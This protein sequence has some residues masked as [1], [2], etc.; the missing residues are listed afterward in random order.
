MLL[1]VATSTFLATFLPLKV[2][3]YISRP[4]YAG[5]INSHHDP[6]LPTCAWTYQHLHGNASFLCLDDDEYPLFDI[7]NA[8]FYHYF[9][10]SQMYKVL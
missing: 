9:S 4:D 10:I 1:K 7:E 8:L 2:L 6:D 5:H 3:C